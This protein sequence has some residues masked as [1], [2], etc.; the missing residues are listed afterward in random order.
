[1][2]KIKIKNV[3]DAIVNLILYARE[4]NDLSSF[5]DFLVYSLYLLRNVEA[6][7]ARANSKR[8]VL[9]ESKDINDSEINFEL[10]I[11]VEDSI[12]TK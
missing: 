5:V 9:N 8:E 7:R 12:I 10:N 11:T 4:I 1:M 6:N 2:N 3:R